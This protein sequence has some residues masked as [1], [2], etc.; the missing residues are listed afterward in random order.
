MSFWLVSFQ[1]PIYTTLGDIAVTSDGHLQ[2]I[3]TVNQKPCSDFI[4]DVYVCA[5][6]NA[7]CEL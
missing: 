3:N 4:I 1:N 5:M 7:K 2:I 6:V